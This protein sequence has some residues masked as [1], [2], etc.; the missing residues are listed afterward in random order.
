[1]SSELNAGLHPKSWAFDSTM[2]IYS[3]MTWQLREA[4]T[5]LMQDSPWKKQQ[6]LVN[7]RWS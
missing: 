2:H 7:K 1:M 5:G 3:R 6:A 4:H